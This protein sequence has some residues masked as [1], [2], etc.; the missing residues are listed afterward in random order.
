[1]IIVAAFKSDIVH[2][3]L[4]FFSQLES[5]DSSHPLSASSRSPLDSDNP[6]D[7]RPY[8]DA[9][10]ALREAHRKIANDDWYV[11][12]LKYFDMLKLIVQMVFCPDQMT[13]CIYKWLD[14]LASLLYLS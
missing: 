12:I 8:K 1:M 2:L 10:L 5:P 3:Y 14:L 11:K 4:S 13:Y 7:W 9:D 6:E